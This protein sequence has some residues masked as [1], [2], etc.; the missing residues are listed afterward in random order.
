MVEN[1]Q[2]NGKAVLENNQNNGKTTLDKKQKSI[3][4]LVNNQNI[5]TITETKRRGRKP[6]PVP[7]H[8]KDTRNKKTVEW[9][10]STVPESIANNDFNLYTAFVL[11][12]ESDEM[13]VKI[14]KNKIICLNTGT[15]FSTDCTGYRISF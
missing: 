3:E 4:S 2:S 15:K 1:N 6:L 11:D 7:M 5:S 13:Y 9:K 14:T 8:S 10:V 12:T